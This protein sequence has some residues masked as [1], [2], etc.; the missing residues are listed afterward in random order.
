MTLSF[1]RTPLLACLCVLLVA[2]AAASLFVGSAPI[3]AGRLIA[4]LAGH[5]DGIAAAILFDLRL[6]R[7]LLGLMVGATLG[8][9]G[10]ALQG[11]LRNPLA[12]P[13]VLGVSNTAALG[14]VAAIYYGLANLHP[15]VLPLLAILSAILSRHAGPARRAVRKPADAHPR[16]DRDRDA[17]RGRDQPRASTFRPIPSRRWRS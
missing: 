12:E 2:A 7:T 11:Y 17:G 6:P 8:L 5:G 9:S 4:A 10:A 13:A 15:V 3:A 1:P 14:A 16:R